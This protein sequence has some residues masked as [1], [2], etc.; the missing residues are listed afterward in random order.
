MNQRK[1]IPVAR[2]VVAFFAVVFGYLLLWPVGDFEPIRYSPPA[3]PAAY[4]IDH[5]LERI[6]ILDLGGRSGPEDVAVDREGRAY[7][8][9]LNGDILRFTA[10]RSDSEV[11]VNT[12]GRP[13]GLVFDAAGNLI[14]ADPFRGL[15]R[16][17]PDRS[18]ETLIPGRAA[19]S[20]PDGETQEAGVEGLCYINNVDLGSDGTIYFTD[21]SN[22][23]CPPDYGGTYRAS[24]FDIIEHRSTGR[25]LAFDP[26]NGVFRVLLDGLQFANGVAVTADGQRAMVVETGA[27]RVLTYY[28][29]GPKA[30]T[31]EPLL[32]AMPG[33]PDNLT[34]GLDGRYWLGFTKPR[35]ALM[36][37]LA[38]WPYLRKVLIR[39]PQSLYPVPPA[40]GHVIAINEEGEILRRLQ[41][42]QPEYPDTTGV[43]ETPDGLYIHSLHAEGLGWLSRSPDWLTARPEQVGMDP[44]ILKAAVD[45]AMQEEMETKGLV[46]LRD[47]AIVA[48]ARAEKHLSFSVAKSFT[49]ALVGIAI[50]EGLLRLD[51]R[52][53]EF[54]DAWDCADKNDPRSRIEIRHLLTLTS[55]LDWHEDWSC[56]MTR[57]R[58]LFRGSDAV[59]M[60]LALFDP[61][62]DYVLNREGHDEPGEVFA[63]STGDPALLSRIIENVTGMTHFAYAREKLFIPMNIRDATWAADSEGSTRSYSHLYLRTRD[64]AKLGQLYL[65]NGKWQGRQLVPA[66]WVRESTRSDVGLSPWYGYL[67]H[68]NLPVKYSRPESTIPSDAFMARGIFGQWV[69]VIPSM[70]LVIAKNANNQCALDEPLFIEKVLAAV[71]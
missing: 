35:S 7:A 43:T 55:G 40:F 71:K 38:D 10:D 16:V 9:T 57:P 4:P 23:F 6:E 33:Y 11:F 62:P 48:E 14:V 25:L 19:I 24:L 26:T 61:P 27:C 60:D 30:G 67:W 41:D 20:S 65:Q 46:I 58:L 64:Y 69:V 32:T 1:L 47:G 2:I 22:R 50:G 49:S 18:I 39:L 53:C 28:L 70:N 59:Y 13:L 36:D 51:D 66:D 63:Y 12:G 21:S 29:S 3:K 17:A 8:A 54:Y 68:T 5:E 34:R 31:A 42:P 52:V 56:P 15:L 37:A 44:H 45:Y